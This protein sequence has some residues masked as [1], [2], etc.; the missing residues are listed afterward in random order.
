MKIA[1]P[2]MHATQ[3]FLLAVPFLFWESSDLDSPRLGS[4]SVDWIPDQLLA[5]IFT[6]D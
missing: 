3:N 4:N 6:V 1:L 2:I 5:V